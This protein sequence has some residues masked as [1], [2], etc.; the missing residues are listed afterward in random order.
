MHLD[1]PYVIFSL[2]NR[3]DLKIIFSNTTEFAKE[4]ILN[5]VGKQI[6]IIFRAYYKY[7]A[8]PSSSLRTVKKRTA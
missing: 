1:K 3:R 7:F 2:I 5:P 6:S 4:N 8:N